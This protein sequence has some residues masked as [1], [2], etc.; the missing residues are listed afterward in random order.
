MLQAVKQAEQNAASISTTL[1]S[2]HL[3]GRC[4]LSQA[5]SFKHSATI[6][7]KHH[8]YDPLC[9]SEFISQNM[10][11][12]CKSQ[13]TEMWLL[14]LHGVSRSALSPSSVHI[15]SVDLCS[16]G[17]CWAK[18]CG[19]T[20][21][22]LCPSIPE[23]LFGFMHLLNRSTLIPSFKGSCMLEEEPREAEQRPVPCSWEVLHPVPLAIGFSWLLFGL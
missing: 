6:L 13:E 14:S 8:E 21:A 18:V 19:S 17:T 10:I 7:L 1:N 20:I 15:L 5:F 16:C 4:E 9:S 23:A 22:V 12:Q 2:S 3:T 11:L